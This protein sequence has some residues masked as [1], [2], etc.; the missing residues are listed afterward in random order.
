M[1]E[2][3]SVSGCSHH[4]DCNSQH[5]SNLTVTFRFKERERTITGQSKDIIACLVD[6]MSNIGHNLVVRES[7]APRVQSKCIVFTEISADGGRGYRW[8]IGVHSRLLE[9]TAFSVSAVPN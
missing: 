6:G 7:I 2:I 3:M 9:A 4:N 5:P 1:A 8:S